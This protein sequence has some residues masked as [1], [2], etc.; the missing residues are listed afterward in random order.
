MDDKIKID[1]LIM[2][3]IG[4]GEGILK[5]ENCNFS[6]IWGGVNKIRKCLFSYLSWDFQVGWN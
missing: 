3:I 6:G 5:A 2:L 4:E 1:S